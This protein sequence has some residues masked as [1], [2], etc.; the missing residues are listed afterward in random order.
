M[1]AKND[2]TGDSIISKVNSKAYEENI[3]RIFGEQRKKRLEEKKKA[4][5]EY[6]AKVKAETELRLSDAPS[7]GEQRL[8]NVGQLEVYNEGNWN[9]KTTQ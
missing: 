7:N 4:D 2:I 3:D 5:A 1:A 6:W 8:N 9:V